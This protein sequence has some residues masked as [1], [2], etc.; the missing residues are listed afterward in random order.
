MNLSLPP[1]RQVALCDCGQILYF[2]VVP[3][4]NGLVREYCIQ[5]GTVSRPTQTR[6]MVKCQDCPKDFAVSNRR[7]FPPSRCP[8]CTQKRKRQQR[9]DFRRRAAA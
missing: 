8:D 5:C 1:I 6:K 3:F 7:S 9:A 4:S 2:E